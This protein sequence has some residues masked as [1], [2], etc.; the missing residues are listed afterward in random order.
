MAYGILR[1]NWQ[2]TVWIHPVVLNKKGFGSQVKS[3]KSF[4]ISWNY[5]TKMHLQLLFL[6]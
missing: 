4:L 1:Q 2:F 3:V 6:L 5:L